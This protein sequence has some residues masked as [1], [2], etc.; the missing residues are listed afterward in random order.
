MINLTDIINELKRDKSIS[1]IDDKREQIIKTIPFVINNKNYKVLIVDKN[2]NGESVVKIYF[3][4]DDEWRKLQ[5]IDFKTPEEYQDAIS[6]NK[7]GIT[8]TGDAMVIF[9]KVYN[10]ILDYIEKYQPKYVGFEAYESNR[11]SL[12]DK[13]CNQANKDLSGISYVKMNI[14]PENNEK[15]DNNKDFW[16]EKINV[17]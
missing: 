16:F 12:Y 3:V 6:K 11:Q 8:N 1:H 7:M 2:L 14:N 15:I 10:I 13:I 4:N 17:K 9:S 5:R